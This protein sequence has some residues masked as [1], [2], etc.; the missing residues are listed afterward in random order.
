MTELRISPDLA[1]P[2]EAVTESLGILGQRGAGKSTAAVVLAEEMWK[3]KLPWVAVDPKGDWY[4]IRSSAD[5]KKPG[6]A[7]P[8]FGGLH[9]DVPLEVGS[10]ALV[11]DLVV[12][13]NLTA[14]L[15]VSDFSKGERAKFLI[16]FFDRLYKRHRQDP[17]ARHVFLE[18]AHEYIPQQVAGRDGTAQL[19]DSASRIVLQ[20]RSFGL[21]STTASQRSARLHKDVL[22]QIGTLIAMRTTGPQDRKAI[23][24]WVEFHD[25]GKELVASL[26]G[27]KSGEAWVWSPQWLGLMER[28]RFR[29]RETFDSGATPGAGQTVRAPAT[30]ADVDLAAIKEQMAE[31]I[32]RAKADDPAELRKRIK[33][34]ERQLAQRPTET[35]EVEVVRE[36]IPGEL[37]G[38]VN[39]ARVALLDAADSLT[40]T[41][42]ILAET[43][44]RAYQRNE[45]AGHGRKDLP[46][47]G[48]T[49][50]GPRA[51]AHRPGPGR[52]AQRADPPARREPSRAAV[53]RS[54]SGVNIGGG[55]P[56]RILIALAQH[57]PE[58]L[59]QRRVAA[60]VGVKQKTSTMRNALSALRGHGFITGSDPIAITEAGLAE[61]GDVTDGLPTGP[62]L[63]EHWR[64][65]L[66]E[67]APRRIFDLLVETWPSDELSP[68]DIAEYAEVLP[69]TSTLRNAMSKLR[70]L[71]LV[72]GW[73]ANDDLME[74]IR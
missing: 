63:L 28:I 20:G 52:A 25:Q 34:L 50:G 32:E 65:K 55:A 42:A 59:T 43:E 21:G 72:D 48:A 18:E 60:L 31:T 70:S 19:K 16:A 13:A 53:P 39:Q 8:V 51:V 17:Q 74:A 68:G 2:T 40:A 73:R 41:S 56:K 61:V 26:S 15:D 1:L 10:G 62:E 71:G 36:V 54:A 58:P 47:A 9:G 24:A 69:G 12:D 66:G 27:L 4:G 67:G 57:H 37:I 30:L 44:Q 14:V 45:E 7:L 22:T 11:A 38:V 5:G 46:R 23:E 35:I 33:E 64:S 29:R 3:A 49:S 6:L